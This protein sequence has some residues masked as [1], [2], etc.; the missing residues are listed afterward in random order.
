MKIATPITL[1]YIET[2][3]AKLLVGRI[4]EPIAE[5]S[6]VVFHRVS[7]DEYQ[8][9]VVSQSGDQSDPVSLASILPAELIDANEQVHAA[10][11]A[12]QARRAPTKAAR[13]RKAKRT[14]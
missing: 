12:T 13:K 8:L 2:A 1:T 14:Q 6:F 5:D 10:M 11:I 7:A 4:E 9:Q 3:T